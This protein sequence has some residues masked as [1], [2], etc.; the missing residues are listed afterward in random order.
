MKINEVSKL[1]GKELFE[2]LD[3]DNKTGFKTED[4]VKIV[5]Q[6]Q[7]GEWDEIDGD[8]FLA[9]LDADLAANDTE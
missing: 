7:S 1:T 9:E 2:A 8:D 3:R 6:D 4:L 5:E